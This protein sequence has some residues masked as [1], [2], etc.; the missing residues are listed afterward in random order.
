MIQ[1]NLPG[2]WSNYC[3]IRRGVKQWAKR[4]AIGC[5]RTT[6]SGPWN[7][8]SRTHFKA[9]SNPSVRKPAKHT[10]CRWAKENWLDILLPRDHVDAVL[11]ASVLGCGARSWSYGDEAA[12]RNLPALCH[13][14]S[15][16]SPRNSPLLRN[17]AISVDGRVLRD[18]RLLVPHPGAK[19]VPERFHK[20]DLHV[21]LQPG[22]VFYH[23]D[24]Y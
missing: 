21:C 3:A 4:H 8:P 1:Q 13:C 19:G 6:I 7:A 11:P 10:R 12:G 2:A 22:A 15:G 17:A 14:L 23:H 18:R 24:H 16:A 9:C 5:W 20:S